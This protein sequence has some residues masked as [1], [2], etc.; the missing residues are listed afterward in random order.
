MTDSL[1]DRLRAG[2]LPV[3][4][5]LHQHPFLL[6]LA[7]GTLPGE[8]FRFYLEQNLMY[9]PEYSRA[10]ALGAAN[11]RDAAELDAFA[12]AL[13]NIVETE[14]PEN[15]ALLGQIVEL[16]AEDRGGT[17]AMAPGNLAYTSF[18]L[19]AA[20]RGGPLEVMTAIMPCAWSYGEI[21]ASLDLAANDHPVYRN[22]VA[23]F[24]GDE[25]AEVV[26]RMKAQL[27]AF[28]A[29]A[30]FDEGLLLETFKNGARLELGFWEMAYTLE[31]WPDLTLDA[32]VA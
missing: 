30:G 25:Y 26:E 23:F 22:W 10:I 29:V 13:R 7:A 9:L 8:K 14:I 31:Q 12:A 28:A 27:E 3:W 24:A 4:E 6:E 18:L 32:S 21:A 20:F 1:C 11:S 5:S 16:G 19:A 17:L 15:E 2:C